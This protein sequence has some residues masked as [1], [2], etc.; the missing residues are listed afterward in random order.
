[1][2]LIQRF[3]TFWG[4]LL[5]RLG[6]HEARYLPS[7]PGYMGGVFGPQYCQRGCGWATKGVPYPKFIPT[8]PFK[9]ARQP[10]EHC[11]R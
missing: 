7:R 6:Q 11:G 3:K 4:R 5:C 10:C 1:V 8:P 2:N 9:P